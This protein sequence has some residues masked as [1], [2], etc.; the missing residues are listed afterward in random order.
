MKCKLLTRIFLTM[1]M[2]IKLDILTTKNLIF[3]QESPI[4]KNIHIMM[5]K[6]LSKLF[7]LQVTNLGII[8]TAIM[9]LNNYGGITL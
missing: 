5:L 4:T 1:Y 6:I 8:L 7:I 2:D 3:L 9:I